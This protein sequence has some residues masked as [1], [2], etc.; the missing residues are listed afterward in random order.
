M[1]FNDAAAPE[2]NDLLDPK[3]DERNV[4]FQDKPLMPT[5]T[6]DG[7]EPGFL[8][9]TPLGDAW[10]GVGA[11]K[12]A[13]GG[14]DI[15]TN[16]YGAALKASAAASGVVD[17]L[18]FRKNLALG[19]PLAKMD[20]FNIVGGLLMGWML[21]NVEP[22]RKALDWVTGN[23]DMVKAYSESWTKISTALSEAAKTWNT[24]LEKG[25]SDW[26]G[27][28]SDA[29]KA[30]ADAFMADI[31]AQASLADSLSKVNAALGNLVEGVRGVVT[32][33]LNTLAG[34]LVEAAAIIIASGGTASVAAVVRATTGI[35]TGAMS[36][37]NALAHL[38]TET[39]TILGMVPNI[40]QIVQGVTRAGIT[41]A[42]A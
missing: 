42:T 14:Q 29:Y 13:V 31:E 10:E 3:V 17:V 26:A 33:I 8:K 18:E 21:E 2:G 36:I 28:A 22:L 23:P 19:V 30:K 9:G 38:A 7:A 32:E 27:A 20:P 40:I 41:A 6:S 34:I 24:E 25:V 16:L 39:S 1:V 15:G 12:A 37:S 35:S 11:V 5:L 4:Y